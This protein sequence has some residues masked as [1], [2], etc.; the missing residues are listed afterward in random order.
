MNLHERV[1]ARMADCRSKLEIIDRAISDEI[2]QRNDKRHSRLLLFLHMEKRAYSL[3]LTE[4]NTIDQG[5]REHKVESAALLSELKNVPDC[6]NAQE[7]ESKKTQV[8]KRTY[9]IF[10]VGGN[11]D[12]L[13]MTPA[14]RTLK[15]RYPECKIHVYCTRRS[16]REVLKNNQYIDRLKL[17]STW[18][19]TICHLLYNLK[20]IARYL[21]GD[22]NSKPNFLY[23]RFKPIEIQF[24][25]F[26]RLSP[27]L[28]YSKSAA[29]IIGEMIG[30][31]IDHSRPDCFLTEGEKIEGKKIV[32]KYANPVAIQV[33]AGYSP[34]KEWPIENW[35]ELVQSNPSY[36]FLQL[37][38]AN[39]KLVKGAVDLRGT[40]I[41]E[42]F[43]IIKAAKAFIGIDSLFAH[44]ATALQTPAVVLFGASTPTVFGYEWNRNLYHPPRCSPCLDIIISDPCPYGR[45]CMSNIT[46]SEVGNALSLSLTT[47]ANGKGNTDCV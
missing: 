11:G 13:L 39:E 22:E 35:E 8:N 14:L 4:L 37:G 45:K 32:S 43:A 5:F 41:R 44:A 18:E 23:N 25:D 21:P 24:F 3:A 46:V 1:E 26:G 36:N 40:S 33:T 10:T 30:I 27:G 17:L 31:R 28:F 42:A 19:Q 15:Q 34:N 47:A 29:E 2:R 20:L 38:L 16:H 12:M 7:S 6:G 9:R